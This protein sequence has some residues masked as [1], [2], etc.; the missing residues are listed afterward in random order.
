MTCRDISQLCTEHAE[1]ALSVERTR[2]FE[3]HL[4]G[5]PRCEEYVRQLR[6]VRD[7]LPLTAIDP[8]DEPL[9]DEMWKHLVGHF[10]ASTG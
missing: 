5:C 1:G 8:C 7:I 3:K 10:R 6:V 2:A 4:A 9:S